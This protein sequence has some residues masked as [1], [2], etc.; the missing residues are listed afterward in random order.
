MQTTKTIVAAAAS[1]NAEREPLTMQKRVGSTVY[2]VTVR[3]CENAKETL[4]DKI[5]RLIEMEVQDEHRA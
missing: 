4:E 1:K 5:L 2:S 3:F